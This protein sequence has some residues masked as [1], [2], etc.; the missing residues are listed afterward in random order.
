M[1]IYVPREA[2]HA[3]PLPPHDY[4]QSTRALLHLLVARHSAASF[5]VSTICGGVGRALYEAA[6]A[7]AK[8]AGVSLTCEVNSRQRC[9]LR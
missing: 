9:A 1:S 7:E 4:Q 2:H 6:A 3:S 8:N 5:R